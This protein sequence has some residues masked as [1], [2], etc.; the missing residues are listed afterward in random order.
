MPRLPQV[1]SDVSPRT[2]PLSIGVAE[3][4][5]DAVA[6]LG[7]DASG[8]G[9]EIVQKQIHLQQLNDYTTGITSGQLAIDAAARTERENP[10]FRTQPDRINKAAQI[11][12]GNTLKDQRYPEVRAQLQQQL[13]E[14]RVQAVSAAR[15]DSFNKEKDYGQSMF[16]TSLEADRNRLNTL[17]GP[18][19]DFELSHVV[20]K[21]DA[22]LQAGLFDH[23]QMAQIMKGF[24]SGIAEDQANIDGII[25]PEKTA[26]ELVSGTTYNAIEPSARLRLAQQILEQDNKRQEER[27]K[28]IKEM[29]EGDVTSATDLALKGQL[30][31][32]N[33][34][35]L[36]G[37]Y[38]GLH[39]PI[40]RE[41]YEHLF[42]LI[43]KPPQQPPSDPATKAW[44]KIAV[45]SMDPPSFATLSKLYNGGHGPLNLNDFTDFSV[46]REKNAK[47][48][49]LE[50]RAQTEQVLAKDF[51]GDAQVHADA[52]KALQSGMTLPQ[53]EQKFKPLVEGLDGLSRAS[54]E[55]SFRAAR[56]A[57][58]SAQKAQTNWNSAH[59]ILG[60]LGKDNPNDAVALA[61]KTDY[62]NAASKADRDLGPTKKPEGRIVYQ[63]GRTAISIG[64]R[65]ILQ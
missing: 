42:D 48:L 35:D 55:G 18:E 24:S 61:K 45:N 22:A 50:G 52:L 33:L 7:Q 13:D 38:D 16:L 14:R 40:D 64:G 31:F 11:I 8:I 41:N 32:Q 21:S 46:E 2:A 1:V 9:E 30:T 19:R 54:V 10:D 29:Q 57:F 36:K 37:R 65:L 34:E 44:A 6:R 56:T 3:L 39:V 59:Y 51:G 25:S 15:T 27:V 4:P 17:S 58:E 28:Q 43:N 12:I 23:V 62:L 47:S 60:A 20:G 49:F 26:A 63:N 5:G 53:I